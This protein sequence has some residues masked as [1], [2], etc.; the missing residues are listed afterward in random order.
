MREWLKAARKEA[1]MT[2]REMAVRL[3]I[4]E[5]YYYRIETG[6]KKADMDILLA[7]KLSTILPVP[8]QTIVDYE[9]H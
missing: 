6:E 7:Y 9:T 3:G 4:S 8:L 1:G 5:S 2:C